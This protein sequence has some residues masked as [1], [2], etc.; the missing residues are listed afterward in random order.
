MKRLP[1]GKLGFIGVLRI[2]P[3]VLDVE[4]SPVWCEMD[5]VSVEKG[6]GRVWGEMR[7]RV[8]SVFHSEVSEGGR[9]WGP[10]DVST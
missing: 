2:W 1:A 9:D 4:Y 6:C 3:G 5:R 7:T 10:P 8:A